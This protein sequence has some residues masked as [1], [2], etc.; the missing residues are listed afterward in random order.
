MSRL[1]IGVRIRQMRRQGRLS[2]GALEAK[3]GLTKSYLSKVERGVTVPSIASVLK[4]ARAFG[5]DVAQL[6]GEKTGDATICVVTRAE[7]KRMA[8]SGSGT[9]YVYEA[10]AHKRRSKCMEPFIMR[11]PQR[12]AT[13]ELFDHEGEELIFV[14]KGRVEVNFADRRVVLAAGDCVYFD[15]HLLHRSRSLGRTPAETLVVIGAP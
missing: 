11:P 12:F 14:L 15:A 4:L 9:G 6:F 2:L 7:R 10:I 8:R 13:D 1:S 3:T 5:V